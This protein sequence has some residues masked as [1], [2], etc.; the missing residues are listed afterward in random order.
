MAYPA[1]TYPH[2]PQYEYNQQQQPVIL[3]QPGLQNI[4]IYKQFKMSNSEYI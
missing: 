1:S 2:P 3:E 4:I